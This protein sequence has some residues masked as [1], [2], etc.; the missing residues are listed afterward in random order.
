M[1]GILF[2]AIMIFTLRM[3][4]GGQDLKQVLSFVRDI[5]VGY[6]LLIMLIALGFTA[7]DG[8]VIW[9]LLRVMGGHTGLLRCIGYAY[10]GFFFSGI[11]PSATG[12]QPMQIYYMKRDGNRMADSSVALMTLMAVYKLVLVVMGVAMWIFWKEPLKAELRGYYYL[13]WIGMV[14]NLGLVLVLLMLMLTPGLVRGIFHRMEGALIRM[15][16]LRPSDTRR[17]RMDRSLMRYQ[18]MVHF[19]FLHKEV[20]LK[21]F[22]LAVLQRC[23]V[24]GLTGLV[25]RSLGLSEVSVAAVAGLQMAIYIAVNMLPV[26]GSQGITEVMYQ[27][28]FARIFPGKTVLASLCITRGASF[29]LL[30]VVGMIAVGLLTRKYKSVEPPQR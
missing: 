7:I 8:V 23:M 18:A 27:T 6:M 10:V 3:V 13:F 9:Y 28:A 26:P 20:L 19:L 15:H 12:G 24:Y 16:L 14:L 21:V 5:P 25:Y 4:F 11:T 30:M 2:A 1:Y 29:Y 22:L 17:E